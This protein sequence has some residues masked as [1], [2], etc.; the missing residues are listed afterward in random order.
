MKRFKFKL[1]TVHD[2]REMQ[3]ERAE[4]D[5][6]EAG[7]RVAQAEAQLAKIEY[8]LEEAASSY[9]RSLQSGEVDPF[10]SSLHTNFLNFLSQH[11]TSA[12]AQLTKM[13]S[14]YDNCRK[15]AIEAARAVE[16]TGKLRQRQR[17]RYK[18]EAE[19]AEQSMLDEMA[20][21]LA[22]RRTNL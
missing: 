19:R 6:A 18:L 13:K 20:M 15:L 11:L 22:G 10:E 5:L 4:Q 17:A 1:Q 2:L 8:R 9:A 7:A 3:R 14:E 12:R 21:L 16:A